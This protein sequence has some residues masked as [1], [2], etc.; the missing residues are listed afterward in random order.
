MS[1]SKPRGVGF[2][3]LSDD[4]SYP[5]ITGEEDDYHE[6]TDEDTLLTEELA[7]KLAKEDS[8]K[9]S[10]AAAQLRSLKL[11]P[12][13]L[14]EE[15]KVSSCGNCNLG[16]ALRCDGA[17]HWHASAFKTGEKIRLLN[18]YVQL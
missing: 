4:L 2:F 6:L 5:T 18:N 9:R 3:D 12:D 11:G 14:T 10:E 13:V 15:V 1:Q 17:L 16:D 7:K 8:A